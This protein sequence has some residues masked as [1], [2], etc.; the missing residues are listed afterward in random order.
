MPEMPIEMV[1]PSERSPRDAGRT[2]G[3]D[4]PTPHGRL[5]RF[6]CHKTSQRPIHDARSAYR[7][8]GSLPTTF[9]ER[10]RQEVGGVWSQHCA[11]AS[12]PGCPSSF[13][14]DRRGNE[15]RGLPLPRRLE[16][17]TRLT[18]LFGVSRI[19][20]T[21]HSTGTRFG[22]KRC[23]LLISLGRG[24]ANL[25]PVRFQRH[26]D[27]TTGDL[28]VNR[29]RS[30]GSVGKKESKQARSRT[31]QESMNWWVGDESY[32]YCPLCLCV[33]YVRGG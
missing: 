11:A 10:S 21:R 19:S 26:P 28:R 5:K 14:K 23:S 8:N 18:N 12:V 20:A 16:E 15:Y 30:N 2:K 24:G 33:I 22:P 1:P 9:R 13:S 7:E 31:G 4:D 3:L 27:G 25:P 6:M 29:D 17:G 32:A